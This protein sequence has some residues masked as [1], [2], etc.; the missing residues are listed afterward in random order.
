M[1]VVQKYLHRCVR[2]FRYLNAV[3]AKYMCK[4][5]IVCWILSQNEQIYLRV[6]VNVIGEQANQRHSATQLTESQ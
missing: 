3:R 1:N 2:A 5:R 4:G 6:A